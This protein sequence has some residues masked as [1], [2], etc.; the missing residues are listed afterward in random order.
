M[1]DTRNIVVLGAS[2]GGLSAAHYT[3]RHI[4]PKLKG[5]SEKYILHLVDQSTHFW[6]HHGAPR[7]IVSVKDMKHSQYFAPIMDG[8]SQY[9]EFKDSIVF[10]QGTITNVD[11]SARIVTMQKAE[12]GEETLSYYAL[13]IGTG[14]KSPT[15]LTTYHGDH[16]VSQKALDAMNEKLATAKEVVVGGG[17]PLGVEI[18]GEL[19]SYLSGKA[20][21]TLITSNDKL[22]DV[23]RKS[24]ADKAQK[25]L[26]KA[27]VKVVYGVR[28]LG[29]EEGPDGK[30][31][32]KLDNGETM[33]VDV[34][35][36]AVGVTPNTGFLP[37][38]LKTSKGYVKANAKTMR[39]DEAGPHVYAVGDVA[40]VNKGGVM[41]LFDT[42]PVFGANMS[43][44][45]LAEAKA[46]TVAERQY[47]MGNQ[48]TQLVP[49]GKKTGVGAFNGWSM[50]A[51][52]VSQFKGKDYMVGQ[53]PPI[54]Q[55]TKWS[56]A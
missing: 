24:L 38:S 41:N 42:I 50:P 17:G 21:V 40:G 54:T 27:G 19:G 20:K 16:T 15:P 13:V 8:F 48:E 18:A 5:S 25:Q 47:K 33:S 32:V 46:G 14:I 51:F 52:F 23:L 34:Y 9:S 36:P 30:A 56:K 49:V 6:W 44:D 35:I 29:S 22:F 10:H 12:G 39:V 11:N 3:V 7:A 2:F 28:V 55:G 26:E 4:L 43:H 53:M 45:L 31:N 37:E 1:S